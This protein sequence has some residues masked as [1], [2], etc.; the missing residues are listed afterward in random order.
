MRI[1][2]MFVLLLAA[3]CLAVPVGCGGGGG[4]GAAVDHSTID[5]AL[6]EYSGF[7][8]MISADISARDD[9]G[10]FDSGNESDYPPWGGTLDLRLDGTFDLSLTFSGNSNYGFGI[11]GQNPSGAVWT[12]YTSPTEPG[13]LNP[14]S[15][16]SIQGGVMTVVQTWDMVMDGTLIHFRRILRWMKS[17][18]Y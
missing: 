1:R 14:Q 8:Q 11:W 16:A 15:A 2:S 13:I 6:S 9:Y 12:V 10:N 17:T 7:W 18:D 4:G 5:L 3:W